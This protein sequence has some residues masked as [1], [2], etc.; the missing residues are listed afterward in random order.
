[1]LNVYWNDRST[2]IGQQFLA[3]EP[4][5]EKEKLA[6]YANKAAYALGIDMMLVG[7]N[8]LNE[9]GW[10]TFVARLSQYILV[11][12]YDAEYL[13]RRL[14]VYEQYKGVGTNVPDKT[15]AQWRKV[16][17]GIVED[18]AR[19]FLWEAHKLNK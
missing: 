7:V 18:D 2:E 15:P 3:L 6:A 17:S 19:Y 13:A 4:G 1:M 9:K 12:R 14:K 10:D 5:P 11:K 8:R 16:L